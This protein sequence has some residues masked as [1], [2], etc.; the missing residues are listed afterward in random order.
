MRIIKDVLYPPG[1]G[2]NLVACHCLK[3]ALTQQFTHPVVAVVELLKGT[4][5]ALK[6]GG[7]VAYGGVGDAG[8]QFISHAPHSIKCCGRGWGAFLL[9]FY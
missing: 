5:D 4:P 2:H 8:V 3:G 1:S 6:P 7:I 9:G